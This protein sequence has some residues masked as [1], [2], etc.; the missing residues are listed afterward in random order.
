MNPRDPLND[1][2]KK[3]EHSESNDISSKEK[4]WAMLENKLEQPAR[5]ETKELSLS[6]KWLAAAAVILFA[7][8]TYLFVKPTDKQTPIMVKTETV[9]K[10]IHQR[11]L[12]KLRRPLHKMILQKI[13]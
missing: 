3:L 11:S 6:R 1:I 5:K 10:Q 13:R 9:G 12:L 7:G 8:V 4:V 2:F